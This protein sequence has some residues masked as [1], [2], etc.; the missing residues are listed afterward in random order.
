MELLRPYYLFLLPMVALV[1]WQLKRRCPKQS[2]QQL[3]APHL[4]KQLVTGDTA[5]QQGVNLIA[6]LLVIAVIALS[7]PSFRSHEVPIKQI[8]PARVIVMDMSAN[9]LATDLKPNRLTQA[10]FKALDLVKQRTEGEQAL[11]AYAG[12]AFTIS[13]LTSD[14]GN[15]LNLIPNLA[16][17]IMPAM[18][19]NPLSGLDLGIELLTNSGYQHGDIIFI[20]GGFS[21][22]QAEQMQSRLKGQPWRISVLATGTAKGAPISLANGDL[23]KDA[24]GNIV[25][26]QLDAPA[27]QQLAR[28]SGGIYVPLSASKRDI[29]LLNNIELLDAQ[30]SR[31]DSQE[32]QQTN[33]AVDDGYWLMFLILPFFLLA[34]RRGQLASIILVGILTVPQPSQASW[35]QNSQKQAY[36]AFEQQNYEQAAQQF[37]DPLWQGSTLY[38]AQDYQGAAEAFKQVETAEGFYNLGNAL[39]MQQDFKGAIAAYDQ[40]LKLA[41]NLQPAK[42]NKAKIEEL[43]KPQEQQ[44]QDQQNNQQSEQQDKEQ[45]GQ[46]QQSQEQQSQSDQSQQPSEDQQSSEQSQQNQSEQN[47]EAQ[48]TQNQAAKNAEN[49]RDQQ[50]DENAQ[51]QDQSQQNEQAQTEPS[52]VPSSQQGSVASPEPSDEQQSAQQAISQAIEGEAEPEEEGPEMPYLLQQMPDDPA[53]LLRNK[54]RLEYQKRQRENR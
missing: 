44:N 49:Q 9:M 30:L 29:E 38:K 34:F 52:P 15:L 7:G 8:S 40:A 24:Q 35:W 20:S 37:D 19:N 23:L 51:R 26:A 27:M 12:D 4:S 50:Q 5:S 39:A 2:L 10:R 53:I 13:P 36:D 25:V 21:A 31:T 46:D 33:Q 32:Q 54:M 17:N 22:S 18:G 14:A 16:P 41:P 43:L 3:I 1:W 6:T 11:I 47:S 42:D 48:N 28:A 45:Q